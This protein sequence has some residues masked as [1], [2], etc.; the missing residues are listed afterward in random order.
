M[1]YHKSALD[2]LEQELQRT[3]SSLESLGEALEEALRRKSTD[4]DTIRRLLRVIDASILSSRLR[5]EGSQRLVTLLRRS[6]PTTRKGRW[7]SA[8]RLP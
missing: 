3:S 2:Q 4:A 1:N 6:T 7:L 8:L 5:L